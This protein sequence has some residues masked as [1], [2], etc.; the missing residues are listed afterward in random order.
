M[1]VQQQQQQQPS[2]QMQTTLDVGMKVFGYDVM[3]GWEN[4]SSCAA[5]SCGYEYRYRKSVGTWSE[6][7]DATLKLHPYMTQGIFGLD[8]STS[9]EAELRRVKNGATDA[10]GAVTFTTRNWSDGESYQMRRTEK[11]YDGVNIWH[12]LNDSVTQYGHAYVDDEVNKVRYVYDDDHYSF[13][14]RNPADLPEDFYLNHYNKTRSPGDGGGPFRLLLHFQF[15]ISNIPNM[16]DRENVALAY[17]FGT[18]PY[19]LNVG[20]YEWRGQNGSQK[21][22]NLRAVFDR[23]NRDNPSLEIQNYIRNPLYWG[24]M[25]YE[26]YQQ[27]SLRYLSDLAVE[28][29]FGKAFHSIRC[30]GDPWNPRDPK[31]SPDCS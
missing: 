12:P 31:D 30:H 6:W 25:V 24:S 28:R 29:D 23:I 4:P 22:K 8:L 3:L 27:R 18:L 19:A 1:P 16:S 14:E 5:P 13:D 26:P 11:T 7:T 15:D 10:Q 2:N 21:Q 20:Y 17:E 9:Y